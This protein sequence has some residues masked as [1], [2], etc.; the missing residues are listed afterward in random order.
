MPAHR[1]G[2]RTVQMVMQLCRCHE[3]VG[4]LPAVP[5]AQSTV[6]VCSVHCTAGMACSTPQGFRTH[7]CKLRMCPGPEW[8]VQLGPV[9]RSV[10]QHVAVSQEPSL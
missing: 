5:H 7:D 9:S 1:Q 3:F 8:H 4:H 10:G 2:A 6:A